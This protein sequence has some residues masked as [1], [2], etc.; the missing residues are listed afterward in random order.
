[1]TFAVGRMKKGPE[2]ALAE[3]YFARFLQVA[4]SL[5]WRFGGLFETPE[6]RAATAFLR[7]ADEGQKLLKALPERGK[8]ILLDEKG[9]SLTSPAF[10]KYLAQYC[11]EGTRHLTIVVGGADGHGDAIRQRAD[12][13][14]SLGAMTW[15]HQIARILLAEQLY[16][17]ATILTAHPYHCS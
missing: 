9:K 13:V 1:M 8:L 16:R 7:I 6:S 5:G 15:P 3:H 10:A 4:P 14:L 17:A 12:M 11:D 2:Q